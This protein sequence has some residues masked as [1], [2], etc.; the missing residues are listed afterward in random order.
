MI[1]TVL[2]I[3]N[4]LL[5]PGILFSQNIRIKEVYAFTEIKKENYTNAID[6]LNNL[7][8]KNQNPEFY[9]AKAEVL[10]KL[11]NFNKALEECQRIDKIKPSYSSKLKLKIYLSINDQENAQIALVENLKSKYKVSLYDLLNSANFD[12]VYNFELDEFILS[13]NFYSQTEKQI[14]Q[15]ERLIQ[16]KKYTQALF[17]VNE[18]LSRNNNIAKAFYLQ[19]KILY[20]NGDTQGS[21]RS[22]NSAL[23]LKKSNPEYLKQ[24]V[25]LNKELKKYDEALQDINKLIRVD[26]YEVDHFI[27]KADMLFKTEQFDE[28]IY[29]TNTILKILPKNPDVL[30]L[31]SKSYYKNK[32]YFEAL[33]AINK[34]L[35]IKSSK[36]SY[37]LR[38]DIYSVT[39]TYEYAKRDYSMYLDIEAYNGDI[40]AK[41]GYA[42]L[43]LGDKKGA[44]SDW[45]KGKR[46]GSYDAVRYLEKYCK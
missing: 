8:S 34:S 23:D 9:L 16:D 21:I 17:I 10:F 5:I 43:K 46:Y 1:K 35:Q 39:N 26:P 3:L 45:E 19:S 30:Y 12:G 6:S 22:I 2:Y 7:I 15:V 32:D 28:A 31:S 36:D 4:I 40:Y 38:G 37:E 14:Y 29:L 11:G 20:I 41:R 44:C 42:R 24:R 25:T 13:R 33:K 27:I 18:I